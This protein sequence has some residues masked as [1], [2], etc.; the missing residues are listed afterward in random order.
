MASYSLATAVW[1][2]RQYDTIDGTHMTRPIAVISLQGACREVDQTLSCTVTWAM[3]GGIPVGSKQSVLR[4]DTVKP[5]QLQ[6]RWKLQ[7]WPP[8]RSQVRPSD[9]CKAACALG[10]ARCLMA[11]REERAC[12]CIVQWQHTSIEHKPLSVRHSDNVKCLHLQRAVCIWI[13][14]CRCKLIL[15]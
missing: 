8:A 6:L 11:P 12:I 7:L 2:K 10:L 9:P 14:I 3:L 4:Q 5:Q 15:E 13:S 1:G